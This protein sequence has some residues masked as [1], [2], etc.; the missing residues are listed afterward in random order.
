M[1]QGICSEEAASYTRIAL[2]HENTILLEGENRR[3]NFRG[4]S[5]ANQRDGLKNML[6]AG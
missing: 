1:Q 3:E 5:V 2:K 6:Q 4:L